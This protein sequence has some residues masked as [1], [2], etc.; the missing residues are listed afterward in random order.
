[1]S[2]VH[3]S[4][5][6]LKVQLKLVSKQIEFIHLIKFEIVCD[7]KTLEIT[8][9]YLATAKT[10]T[11]LVKQFLNIS[12]HCQIVSF[13]NFERYERQLRNSYVQIVEL[14]DNFLLVAH[15]Y[16]NLI[17]FVIMTSE[18]ICSILSRKIL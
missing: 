10:F 7:K 17:Q 4:E 2:I 12:N 3:N 11:N 9:L 13:T 6:I 15:F 1:M 14:K 16:R 8:R 5:D 18:I